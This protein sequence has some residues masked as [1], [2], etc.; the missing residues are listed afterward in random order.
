MTLIL[1]Q[2]IL[3]KHQTMKKLLLL[4]FIFGSL[5]AFSQGTV[6]G[7]LQDADL[8]GPLS[9]ANIVEVGTNNGAISDFDGNFTL[10]VSS[11]SGQ[12]LIT[13][14][15]YSSRTI[16]FTLTNGTAN[17]GTINMEADAASLGEVVI[18]GS[19]VID[20]AEDRETPVAVSTITAAEIQRKAIGNVEVTEALKSTPS[21]FIS[22]QT[23]FGDGQLFLRGFDNSNIAVLLNG[24]PVNAMEDG[25]IFWSNW[26]GIADIATAIQVQRGLGSSKLAISSVLCPLIFEAS[27]SE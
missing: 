14:L 21:V 19:G 13:F 22:G 5:T 3:T 4:V 17:L 15:G 1:Q 24:Q 18:V 12:I 11:N 16:S 20:L 6:T 25:R 9:G 26:A 27:A 7:T 23:G 2:I 10:A 8:G